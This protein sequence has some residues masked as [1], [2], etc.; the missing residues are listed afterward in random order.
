[1]AS[2]NVGNLN[3]FFNFKAKDESSAKEQVTVD[4]EKIRAATKIYSLKEG[5]KLMEYHRAINEAM[6][7][8]G[9]ENPHFLSKLDELLVIARKRVHESGFNYKKKTSRSRDFGSSSSEEVRPKREKISQEVREKRIDELNEDLQEVN[10]QIGFA[11]KHRERCAN[12]KEFTK[13]IEI[14]KEMEEL[15]R[16]KRKYEDEL[17]LLQKKDAATKRVKKCHAKKG[18]AVKPNMKRKKGSILGFLS[19]DN[20]NDCG[21][22][23]ET[24]TEST[25]SGP[26]KEST[27]N[28]TCLTHPEDAVKSTAVPE[29]VVDVLETTSEITHHVCCDDVGTVK[30][31][32]LSTCS[33]TSKEIMEQEGTSSEEHADKDF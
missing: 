11:S 3:L 12:V 16:K 17:A 5:D 10:M 30:D 22:S 28:T 25:S 19:R 31:A 1:M 8:A 6:F 15:R 20:P 27:E 13:A 2:Y 24:T 14:S 29:R 26:L 18:S 21:S 4:I 32:Q 23:S 7:E 9:K 33:N